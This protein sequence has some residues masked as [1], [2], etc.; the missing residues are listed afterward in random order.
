M[1]NLEENREYW[2]GG[3]HWRHRG[4]EWSAWWGSPEAEW[5]VTIHPRIA[6]FLPVGM[7]VEIAP[8][9]GRW[10]Q[11]L[12]RQCDHLVGIDLSA[13]CV[14]AC[15]RRFWRDRSVRFHAND[16]KTLGGV[17][18]DSVDFVF[19]FD[20]LVHVERDVLHSYIG[21]LARV[22]RP[23]AVA[24]LHHSNMGAYPSEQVGRRVPHWR[25]A[26]PSA[27]EVAVE[28]HHVGLSCFKQELLTWG[29]DHDYLSDA[30]TWIAR[31]GSRH[32]RER[33]VIVN[34][35]F[36]EEPARALQTL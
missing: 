6:E 20:S 32:D 21:E 33:D 23:D 5:Q 30:F 4:D 8:G 31:S 29:T 19:S 10:T 34:G 22:L 18:D 2:D 12:R 11:F 36:M 13:K 24:F 27:E 7:L 15:R 26:S 14:R 28:A 3:F 1:P 17:R 35:A 16:G 25:S 9:Y